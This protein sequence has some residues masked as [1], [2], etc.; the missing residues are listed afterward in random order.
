MPFLSIMVLI[1]MYN[2]TKEKYYDVIIIQNNISE[3]TLLLKGSGDQYVLGNSFKSLPDEVYLNG[4]KTNFIG[5]KPKIHLESELNIISLK[6]YTKISSCHSMFIYRSNIIEIDLSKF[7]SSSVVSMNYMFMNCSS[8]KSINFTNFNTS[9]V[10]T[11]CSMF[12]GCS[13]LTSLDLSSFNTAK[14]DNMGHFFM[15]V[16]LYYF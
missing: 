6:W 1:L 5:N 15:N 11:S 10:T 16:L 2:L 3:I 4:N 8:L 7:D 12:N 14:N 9:Q 13:S